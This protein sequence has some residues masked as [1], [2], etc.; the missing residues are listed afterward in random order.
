MK[1][2]INL[3]DLTNVPSSSGFA[4]SL[5][6]IGEGKS[7]FFFPLKRAQLTFYT[8]NLGKKTDF[9]K[10]TRREEQEEE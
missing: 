2:E 6:G 3:K 10:V 8:P 1:H 9:I 5:L 4:D 7:R